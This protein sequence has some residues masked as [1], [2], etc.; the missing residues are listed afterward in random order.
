VA[1]WKIFTKA[2]KLGWA[3]LI[4][5]YN[6]VIWLQV[7]GLSGWLVFLMAVPFVNVILMMYTSYRLAKCFGKGLGFALGL[8]FLSP[9]FLPILGFSDAKYQLPAEYKK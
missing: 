8:I 9:I 5:I 6:F 1:L 3:S 4:P 2:G 7:V